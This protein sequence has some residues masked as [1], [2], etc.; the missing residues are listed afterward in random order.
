MIESGLHHFF[1]HH[2]EVHA[3]LPELTRAVAEGRA[4]PGAAAH[5]LLNYL[6]V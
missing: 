4:T 6:K 1:K 5:T 2:P 3:A